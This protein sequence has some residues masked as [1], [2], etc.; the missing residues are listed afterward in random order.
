MESFLAEACRCRPSLSQWVRWALSSTS[1]DS[2]NMASFLGKETAVSSLFIYGLGF[3]GCFFF[4]LFFSWLASSVSLLQKETQVLLGHP[5][6]FHLWWSPNHSVTVQST[7]CHIY[8]PH[9][10]QCPK[11]GMVTRS[12]RNCGSLTNTMSRQ[13]SVPGLS[14]H[15]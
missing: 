15:E 13:K 12:K 7:V 11:Q 5:R 14:L 1:K 4:F 8:K 10:I 2:Y 6:A 9:P 3:H